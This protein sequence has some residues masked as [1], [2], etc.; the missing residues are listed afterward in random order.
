[1]NTFKRKALS[2]AILGGLAVA[3]GAAQAVYEDPN[4]LGQ[5]LIYPYYTV[6]TAGGNSYNTYLSVV[7]TTT[8]AKA[9]KVRFREGKNS[10]EVLDFNLYL[11]PNDVWTAAIGP[12]DATATSGGVLVT[13]DKS[14]T[15]PAIPAGGQAFRNFSYVGTN[16]DGGPTTLDRTREGYF[17][18]IEMAN[19]VGTAAANVTH[20]A[21][22]T[23]ANCAA[24][25]PE[26]GFTAATNAASLAA[27]SGGLTGTYTLINVS[28]G[29]NFG[30]NATALAQFSSAPIFTDIGNEFTNLASANPPVA[31][32]VSNN[33]T[34]ASGPGTTTYIATYANGRDAVSAT[35]MHSAVIN[36]FALDVA[37]KSA[38][39]WVITFPTKQFYVSPGTGAAIAPFSSNFGSSGSC[40]PISFTFFNREEAGAAASG[41]N[42]S[43][44]PPGPAGASLCWEANEL[45]IISSGA[46][47]SSSILGS[48]NFLGVTVA[49]FQNGWGSLAFTGAPAATTGLS[50]V[51]GTGTVTNVNTGVVAAGATV[52]YRGLP[53]IG[54]MARTLNNGALSCTTFGGSAGTCAGSYGAA[55]DHKY[56]VTA[57]PTP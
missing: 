33:L 38:T 20:N 25:Q 53:V 14:C 47:T 12:A 27:P 40:E 35:M 55:F 4:G 7:N 56:T 3:S 11:S 15:A 39:D 44:L 28:N 46:V 24:V 21:S 6:Q 52:N 37:T 30:G 42:F 45:S 8:R 50:S 26:N 1:M 13:G 23:P 31:V 9:L 32:T 5:A 17:E 16:A 54:F 10:R 49:G 22:G 48:A 29:L 51:A 19:L 36:E 2:C 57:T 34:G 18:I 41:T 43:P